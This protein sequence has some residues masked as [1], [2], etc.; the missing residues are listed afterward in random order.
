[1]LLV[2]TEYHHQKTLFHRQFR[3]TLFCH[4]KDNFQHSRKSKLCTL[5]SDDFCM[6]NDNYCVQNRIEQHVKA[7][8]AFANSVLVRLYTLLLI[9]SKISL[10]S[11]Y[12]SLIT[13]A[14]SIKRQLAALSSGNS[15]NKY[16]FVFSSIR[17]LIFFAVT[18]LPIA[19][20][21]LSI[22]DKTDFRC[23]PSTSIAW[24]GYSGNTFDKKSLDNFGYLFPTTSSA[25]ISYQNLFINN[26]G[27]VFNEDT[28]WISKIVI[29]W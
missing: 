2:N 1:M 23:K 19:I 15:T 7:P 28:I 25:R 8:S 29:Y 17:F 13:S 5:S 3:P 4:I 9:F 11:G 27:T 10:L 20:V 22:S 24:H 21:S 18:E 6:N 26:Y 14:P 16:T 12:S